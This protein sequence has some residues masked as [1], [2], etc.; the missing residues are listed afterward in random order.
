MKHS[1]QHGQD[2]HKN[3]VA[4]TFSQVNSLLLEVWMKTS[5]K[6][7]YLGYIKI[8]KPLWKSNTGLIICKYILMKVV[9]NYFSLT[10]W[11]RKWLRVE[12]MQQSIIIVP[13][14]S[15]MSIKRFVG[16]L[17]NR[18][19]FF[20]RSELIYKNNKFVCSPYITKIIFDV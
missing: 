12:T 13:S 20:V 15:H 2:S 6:K 10:N 5:P 16:I 3:E 14:C 7:K 1:W 17:P 11:I 8:F 18:S 4:H 19:M 9:E